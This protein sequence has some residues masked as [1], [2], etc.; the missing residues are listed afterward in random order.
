LGWTLP[1]GLTVAL[2]PLAA[3]YSPR[4]GGFDRIDPAI[5]LLRYQIWVKLG[6]QL[7]GR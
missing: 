5:R 7:G 3:S 1:S 2:A 6:W 4:V